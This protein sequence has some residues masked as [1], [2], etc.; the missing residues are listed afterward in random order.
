VSVVEPSIFGA[1][2]TGADVEGW[3]L[4][5]LKQWS[6]TYLAELERQHGRTAGELQP[7]RAWVTV[8]SF[9][10]WPEDQ[11]PAVLLLSVGIAAP[12]LKRGDGRYR[13]RWQMGLACICSARTQELS[14][15]LAM[16]YLAA[17]RAILLQRPSLGGHAA[18]INWLDEN[19][20][21]LPL[22]DLRSLSAGQ[23]IFT[24]E[25]EGVVSGDAGPLSPDQP[26]TP[27][28]DPWP[29]WPTAATVEVTV[30]GVEAPAPLP[31]K[32]GTA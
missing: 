15:E 25:V 19:Y 3:C 16:L 14:H 31:P 7:V 4:E 26:L 30:E 22:D 6:P 13:A 32:G 28:T 29:D 10:K 20:D 21:D 24:V 2:V 9:D 1:I 11:L 23:A 8:P 18:G 27:A 12:P 5:T 17:H